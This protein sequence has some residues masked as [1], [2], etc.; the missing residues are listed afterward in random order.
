MLKL[1]R[2]RYMTL[3][4]VLAAVGIAFAA[5]NNHI[6]SSIQNMSKQESRE[7]IRLGEVQ[8]EKLKLETEISIA[9]TDAY[10]E[11]EARTRYGYLKP[12]ELRFVITNPEALYGSGEEAPQ[13]QVV[14]EGDKP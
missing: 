8:N 5:T 1:R 10:I 6:Q 14:E 3:L 7:R 2:V 4:V 9:D 11:N 13:L 12:G